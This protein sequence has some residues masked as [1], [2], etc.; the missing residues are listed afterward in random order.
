MRK[1][2]WAS[3]IPRCDKT[4]AARMT[5]DAAVQVG[6]LYGRAMPHLNEADVSELRRSVQ[7]LLDQGEESL[8]RW[9]S[10]ETQ[11]RHL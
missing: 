6:D 11:E 5:R 10:R 9:C 4:P 3:F 2:Q 1:V 8:S 7:P